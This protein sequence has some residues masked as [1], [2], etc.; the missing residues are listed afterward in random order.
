MHSKISEIFQ[1]EYAFRVLL[2]QGL[3]EDGAEENQRWGRFFPI[4]GTG[5]FMIFEHQQRSH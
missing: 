1:L 4:S 2:T 3:E 5:G